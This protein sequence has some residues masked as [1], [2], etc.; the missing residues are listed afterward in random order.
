MSRWFCSLKRRTVAREFYC[1]R[2]PAL[3]VSSARIIRA[4]TSHN[5]LRRENR[6]YRYPRL[7]VADAGAVG[8]QLERRESKP[9]FPWIRH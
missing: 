4:M 1:A 3:V 7:L 2:K 8:I 6:G 9:R 5:R